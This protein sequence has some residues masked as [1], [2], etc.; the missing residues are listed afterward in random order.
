MEENS[1][2]KFHEAQ[3]ALA[4]QWVGPNYMGQDAPRDVFVKVPQETQEGVV[5]SEATPVKKEKVPLPATYEQAKD[6]IERFEQGADDIRGDEDVADTV[7]QHML[8]DRTSLQDEK[9]LGSEEEE[10]DSYVS[11]LLYIHSKVMIVDD[12]I[13]IMGS[14]NLNDR[15]QRGDGDSEIALVVEDTDMVHSYMDGRPYMATRF[16]ASLRRKL[17]RGGV[18]SISP[19][20]FADCFCHAEHLGL[21]K[22]QN[23]TERTEEETSFMRPAPEPNDDEMDTL[24][25]NAVLDPLSDSTLDLLNG[26]AK[27]NRDIFTELFRPVPTNFIRSWSMYETY[28]PKV[29]TGHVVPEVP[30]QRIK[31]RLALVRGSIVECPLDFLIDDKEFVEGIDWIGLN[32]TLPIYI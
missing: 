16:A 24:E 26:T 1:G 18:G 8:Q 28:V 25:D 2:V 11:E 22:P 31:D 12:R 7:S 15:S 13:V 4:R 21:I 6:I 14:A 19:S 27:K 5:V 20:D 30:L 32:P 9:W 29:K 17:Y 10:R 3:I 23:C